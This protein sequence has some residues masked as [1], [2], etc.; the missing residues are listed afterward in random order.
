M[1]QQIYYKNGVLQLVISYRLDVWAVKKNQLP[2][3][4]NNA[5]ACMWYI[6]NQIEKHE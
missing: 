1:L 6:Q 3:V 2:D 5:N 4:E